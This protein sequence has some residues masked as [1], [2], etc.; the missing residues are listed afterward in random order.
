M[1]RL[2]WLNRRTG[3]RSGLIPKLLPSIPNLFCHLDYSQPNI[4][5]GTH[6]PVKNFFTKAH[7]GKIRN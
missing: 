5:I 2:F 1:T 4:R 7:T 6:S 3:F